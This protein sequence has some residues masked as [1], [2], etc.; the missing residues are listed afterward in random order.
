MSIVKAPEKVSGL[1][2]E[3]I[4][5]GTELQFFWTDVAGADVCALFSALD[6]SGPFDTEQAIAASGAEGLS[7]PTPAD[8]AVFYLVGGRNPTCDDGPLR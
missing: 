7:I 1:S 8:D 6:P 2:V 3:K 5:I 4:N